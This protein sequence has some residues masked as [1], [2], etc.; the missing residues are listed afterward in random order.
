LELLGATLPHAVLAQVIDHVTP[1]PVL[2]FVTTAVKVVLLPTTTD[3]GAFMILTEI[4]LFLLPELPAQALS[5][6]PRTTR[7]NTLADLVGVIAFMIH[8]IG[9]SPRHPDNKTT[10]INCKAWLTQLST[11]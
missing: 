9:R 11:G 6:A 4:E 5:Q 10:L 7:P 3:D 2:S 8:G 1:A